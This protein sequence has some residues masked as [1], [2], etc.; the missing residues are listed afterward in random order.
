MINYYAFGM[1]MPG[2][3][4]TASEYRYAFNGKEKNNEINAGDY[5]FG[6][7]IYNSKIGKWKN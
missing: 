7:R 3:T 5:D 1:Q 2:R 6:D 4:W